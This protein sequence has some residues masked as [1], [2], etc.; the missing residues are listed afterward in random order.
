MN[1]EEMK[2]TPGETY[3]EGSSKLLTQYFKRIMRIEGEL[4]V[5][6]FGD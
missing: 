5:A 2:E 6:F 1:S 3:T 4:R